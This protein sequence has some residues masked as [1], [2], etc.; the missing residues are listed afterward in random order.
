MQAICK[1]SPTYPFFVSLILHHHLIPINTVPHTR[2]CY[3]NNEVYCTTKSHTHTDGIRFP[4][5]TYPTTCQTLRSLSPLSRIVTISSA[6]DV[7]YVP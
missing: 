5:Q 2:S 1:T 4:I 7:S 3:Q 6:F